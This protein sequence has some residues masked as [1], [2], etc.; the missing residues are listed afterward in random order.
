MA[1]LQQLTTLAERAR[2]RFARTEPVADVRRARSR[3]ATRTL[4][5]TDPTL[6]AVQKASIAKPTADELVWNDKIEGRRSEL[7]HSSATI[8][9]DV[10]DTAYWERAIPRSG[11]A[12]PPS[13]DGHTVTRHVGE[14]TSTTSKPPSW[15]HLFY[16]L[17]RA[18]QPTRCLE[19]G[20]SVGMS[21]SY[22]AGALTDNGQGMLITIEG[23]DA[24]ADVAREGLRQIGAADHADV[25]T[26]KFADLL[27]AAIDDLGGI[28][29][30]FVDGHHLREPTLDYFNRIAPAASDGALLIFDDVSPW[31]EGME[32]AWREI[33]ED[34]RV[35]GSLTIAAVG[36]AVVGGVPDGHHTV[37]HIPAR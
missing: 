5:I 13:L 10:E 6:L 28:D 22:I 24:I 32:E 11:H 33:R 25:R 30:A 31:H 1:D 4:S 7:E 15:G 12:H 37:P 14:V 20:T 9:F 3:R 35:T 36:F 21:A 16:R 23:E 19:L 17:T 34:P 29:L 27:G 2:S 8:S 18:L 26:G